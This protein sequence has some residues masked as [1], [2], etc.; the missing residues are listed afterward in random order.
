MAD[1]DVRNGQ[2]AGTDAVEEIGHVIVAFVK[3]HGFFRQGSIKQGFVARLQGAAIDPNPAVSAFKADAVA[4]AGGVNDAAADG[5]SG[6]GLNA[7]NDAVGI[8]EERRVGKECR[9]RWSPYH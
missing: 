8:S 9:S 2:F 7:V 6:R 5:L 4:L 3:A 1:F